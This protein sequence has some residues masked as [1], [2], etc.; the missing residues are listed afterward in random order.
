[1]T[2]E[3]S[4]TSIHTAVGRCLANWSQ[5]EFA[6]HLLF[7]GL[8]RRKFRANDPLLAAFEAN[9]SFDAKRKTLNTFID[10]DDNLPPLFKERVKPLIGK[11]G[12]AAM[13]M[14][15]VAHFSVRIHHDQQTPAGRAMLHPFGTFTGSFFEREPAALSVAQLNERAD[16]FAALA[17]RVFR[18]VTYIKNKNGL[19][20]RH[21]TP[22]ENPDYLLDHPATA[23]AP[24]VVTFGTML[25]D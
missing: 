13:Q 24:P 9:R 3:D 17:D 8:N 16:N 25:E 7:V 6:C 4:E 20:E 23:S 14:S 10:S 18:F 22:V 19:L 1:M 5:V 12:R 15:E 11:L 2:V 21:D